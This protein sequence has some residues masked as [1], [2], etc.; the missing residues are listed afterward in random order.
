MVVTFFVKNSLAPFH[1]LPIERKI[2]TLQQ[3]WA[4]VSRTCRR[5]WYGKLH[6]A[7]RRQFELISPCPVLCGLALCPYPQSPGASKSSG[8]LLDNRDMRPNP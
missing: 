4:D 2:F 6:F 3:S 8:I 5:K 1:R 7:H